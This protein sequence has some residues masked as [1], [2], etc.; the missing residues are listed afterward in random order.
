[1][2]T[3]LTILDN[4]IRT[5]HPLPNAA[6]VRALRLGNAKFAEAVGRFPAAL[7]VLRAAGF[8]EQA[9]E[10]SGAAGAGSSI[11]SVFGGGSA[12]GGSGKVL[13]LSAEAEDDDVTMVVREA[14]A[15]GLADMGATV[16]P[17]PE[18][19]YDARDRAA[20]A[21]AQVEAAFD[22][23]K[24]M[25]VKA[26]GSVSTSVGA[27]ASAVGAAIE[28][29]AAAGAFASAGSAAGSLNGAGAGAGSSGGRDFDVS[30][31]VQGTGNA[32]RVQTQLWRDTWGRGTAST[33]LR[34][35]QTDSSLEPSPVLLPALQR[36]DHFPPPAPFPP[37]SHPPLCSAAGP[38]PPSAAP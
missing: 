9:E 10:G 16:P 8:A 26:D 32:G 2:G 31:R 29:A 22:P 6:R 36:K 21:A 28:A 27:G 13:T 14:V 12:G 23:F 34:C 7:E 38:P 30:F 5:P 24:A 35:P 3:V 25:V 17:A 19:D 15:A 18:V 11:G 33:A 4:L 1:L 37:P 20:A